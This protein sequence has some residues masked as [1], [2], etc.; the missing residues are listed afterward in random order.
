[1]YCSIRCINII[2]KIILGSTVTSY[3]YHSRRKANGL[4]VVQVFVLGLGVYI[5]S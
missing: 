3:M 5:D 1:M 2:L 4:I